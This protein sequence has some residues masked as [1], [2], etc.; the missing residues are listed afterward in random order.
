MTIRHIVRNSLLTLNY[1]HPAAI[2]LALRRGPN[3]TKR[4]LAEVY[5]CSKTDGGLYLPT[6]SLEDLAPTTTQFEVL[7]AADSGGS[8]TITEISSICYLIAARRPKKVLE[9]G[10]YR[11][12]TTLNIAMNAS[13]AEIHTLDLPLDFNPANTEFAHNDS[14]I[15]TTRGVYYYEGREQ[16]SRV[17]QHYGDTAT[18]DYERIGGGVDFCLIDAAHSYEYVRNDTIKALRLMDTDSLMLWHDYGRNDFLAEPQDTWGVSRFLHEIA[19]AGVRIIQGTSLGCLILSREN[20]S[21][22]NKLLDL[23]GG[24]K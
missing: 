24:P 8:M 12:L 11:G 4:Y 7:R 16:A 10:S 14:D 22:L 21:G 20:R 17:H 23:N 3:V 5:R 18:F 19:S 1:L 15:I 9:I 2:T 13:E 6:I